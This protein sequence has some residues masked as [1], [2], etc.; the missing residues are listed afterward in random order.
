MSA[1]SGVLCS[2]SV[3]TSRIFAL[4][5]SYAT[6]ISEGI[7][8]FRPLDRRYIVGPSSG[9]RDAAAPSS[10]TAASLQSAE[11]SARSSTTGALE[12]SVPAWFRCCGNFARSP[13]GGRAIR[14]AV[15][16][17]S[18]IRPASFRAPFGRRR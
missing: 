5:T 16:L 4:R 9:L 11:F 18:P 13:V 10:L 7:E 3:L 14:S 12:Q 17:T 6:Q 8:V 1:Y 2:C 15:N